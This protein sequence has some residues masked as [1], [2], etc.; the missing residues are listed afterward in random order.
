[1]ENILCAD[2]PPKPPVLST[3]LFYLIVDLI[4]YY[5]DLSFQ[6]ELFVPFE[7]ATTYWYFHFFDII[8]Y[9]FL[10]VLEKLF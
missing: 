8:E 9:K 6:L 7:F 3:F 5:F 1:M 10:G 4:H 2:T